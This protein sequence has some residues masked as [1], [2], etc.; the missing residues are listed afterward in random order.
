MRVGRIHEMFMLPVNMFSSV[1]RV[2]GEAVEITA[3]LGVL[4]PKASAFTENCLALFGKTG[5]LTA[6]LFKS[7]LQSP[8]FG[9]GY[10]MLVFSS[11]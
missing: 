5:I 7:F 1:S 8:V 2:T 11:T 3:K 10:V 9:N 6:F 4:D